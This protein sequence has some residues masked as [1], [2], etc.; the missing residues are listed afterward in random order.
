M[1][2]EDVASFDAVAGDL[3]AELGYDASTRGRDGRRLAAYRA[4]ARAWRAVGA[5][6]Q[7]SRLWRRR[8]P[9]LQ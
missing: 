8:H 6:T 4:K 7:S 5:V 2:A 9:L 3:L 1:S